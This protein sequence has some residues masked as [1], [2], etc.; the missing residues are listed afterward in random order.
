MTTLKNS[1]IGDY[2]KTVAVMNVL[3]QNVTQQVANMLANTY[4]VRDGPLYF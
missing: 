3:A 2:N 1:G 4:T